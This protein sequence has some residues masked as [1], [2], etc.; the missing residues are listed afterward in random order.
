MSMNLAEL[1]TYSDIGQLNRLAHTYEIECNTNSKNELIQSIL[2][3]VKRRDRLQKHIRALG[4]EEFHFLLQL[5]LDNRT[6]F[7][8]ED[9][10]AKAKAAYPAEAEKSTYRALVSR[11]LKNGW[12]F[13]DVGRFSSLF[14]VPSDLRQ[15]IRNEIRT[16]LQ[17]RLAFA[18]EVKIYRDEGA[19]ILED[20]VIFLRYVRDYEP[21]VT[22][23]G[24]IYRRHQ[25]QLMELFAVPEELVPKGG[26]RFGYGRYFKDY[27]DRFS[28]IYDYCFFRGF[29]EEG[30]DRLRLAD[31]GAIFLAQFAQSGSRLHEWSPLIKFWMRLYKRPVAQLPLHVQLLQLLLADR[32]VREDALIRLLRPWVRPYYYD[33]PENIVTTRI[34]KMMVHLGLLQRAETGAEKAYRTAPPAEKLL[35]KVEAFSARAINLEK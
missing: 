23:E 24:V 27:P 25:Q 1:L 13:P 22:N 6:A 28:L 21:Q 9:L 33:T 15:D 19:A 32:W 31:N 11:A 7:T 16:F 12:I 14:Q 2:S 4:A 35:A 34:L 29:I 18:E 5:M 17:E 30:P 3:S 10:H 26:W 8:L 20:L